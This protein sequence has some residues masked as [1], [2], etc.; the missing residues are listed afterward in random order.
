M[1][2]RTEERLEKLGCLA[3]LIGLG[4]F[5]YLAFSSNWA[6][7]LAVA[8]SIGVGVLIVRIGK[9]RDHRRNVEALRRAFAPSGL[10]VP[11]LEESNSHGFSG[12]TLTFPSEADLKRADAL[13]CIAAFKQTIQALYGHTG[14]KQNPF[15]A[16]LAV[17]VTY[18]C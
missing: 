1:N 12:F 10:A 7:T 14:G 15:D 6:Y 4:V 11:Q 8:G 5:G 18:E 9:K 2:P 17:A 16:E 13:G 3:V